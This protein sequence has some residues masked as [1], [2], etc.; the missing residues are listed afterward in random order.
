M[1]NQGLC[2]KSLARLNRKIFMM[3]MFPTVIKIK[4]TFLI[5]YKYH[6]TFLIQFI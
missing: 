2:L 4:I 6:F 1:G 3:K 5:S